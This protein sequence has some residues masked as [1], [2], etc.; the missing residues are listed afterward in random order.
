[1]ITR[2]LDLLNASSALFSY[3]ALLPVTHQNAICQRLKKIQ[4]IK[5]ASCIVENR[6]VLQ[7][8][9]RPFA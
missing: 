9:D 3:E 5:G 6:M 8:P 1:M 7:V 4:L 2:L